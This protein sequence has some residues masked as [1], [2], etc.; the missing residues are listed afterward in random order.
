[1]AAS[2]PGNNVFQNTSSNGFSNQDKKTNKQNGKSGNV[3]AC[4]F[5]PNCYRP[6][7]YFRHPKRDSGLGKGN[8]HENAKGT[9]KQKV[10]RWDPNCKTPN[11][12]FRHPQRDAAAG[13]QPSNS[14]PFGQTKFGQTSNP[15]GGNLFNG[16]R[17]QNINTLK[18]RMKRSP[19][20]NSLQNQNAFQTQ[21]NNSFA[22][23]SQGSNQQRKK[24]RIKRKKSRNNR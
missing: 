6:D 19:E 14:N 22:G 21:Q 4:R 1:M 15:N 10:C 11:C 18:S 20:T 5:D 16:T 2:G 3:A 7:C 12:W 24:V 17:Q 8:S 9:G 13:Q 23:F